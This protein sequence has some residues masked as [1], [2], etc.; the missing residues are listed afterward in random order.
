MSTPIERGPLLTGVAIIGAVFLGFGT[1][2]GTAPLSSAAIAPG[3]VR[4]DSHRKTLKHLEGGVIDHILARNGQHVAAGQV[5]VRLNPAKARSELAQLRRERDTLLARQA[6]LEAE[7]TGAATFAPPPGQSSADPVVAAEKQVLVTTRQAIR[8][9]QAVLARARDAARVEEGAARAALAALDRQRELVRAD[10]E[11]VA[12]LVAKGL[13]RRPR[14]RALER[15]AVKVD[16]ERA[17]ARSRIAKARQDHV[18]AGLQMDD[19]ASQ[20]EAQAATEL[21]E[22]NARLADLAQ[23]LPAAEDV[24][25]RTDIT[26]PVAG[27]VTELRHFTPGAVLSPG[28]AVLDL[29]PEG[30]QL[31]INARVQPQD[32]DQVHPGLSAEIRLP[33]FHQRRMPPLEGTVVDVSAD[34]LVQDDTGQPYYAATVRVDARGLPLLPGMPAETLILTGRRTALQYMLEPVTDGFRRAFRED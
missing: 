22:V 15:E 2:A 33:A 8:S 20:R 30:D 12:P 31:V 14:L 13:E 5:L 28:E 25:R 24:L 23:R 11:A 18:T 32:I 3:E 16:S 19:V 26:A 21:Q 6:R 1:W 29:V 27:V 9:Q 7:R 34:T 10:M 17:Q 4:A